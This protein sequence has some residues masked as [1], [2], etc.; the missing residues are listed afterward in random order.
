VRKTMSFCWVWC[1]FWWGVGY[2]FVL[3]GLWGGFCGFCGGLLLC[4]CGVGYWDVC[5]GVWLLGVG[6]FLRWPG[7]DLP[8]RGAGCS[9]SPLDRRG[10]SKGGPGRTNWTAGGTDSRLNN[11]NGEIMRRL[12]AEYSRGPLFGP[13]RGRHGPRCTKAWGGQSDFNWKRGNLHGD[14]GEVLKRDTY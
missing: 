6:L 7:A 9:R 2:V 11:Q 4:W 13:T 14:G 12:A 10:G 3:L 5:W 1:F 8:P